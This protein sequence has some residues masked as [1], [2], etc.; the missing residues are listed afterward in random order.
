MPAASTRPCLELVATVTGRRSA[1]PLDRLSCPRA[2][3]EWLAAIGLPIRQATSPTELDDLRA[4]REA[5]YH[6]LAIRAGLA[7]AHH[8]EAHVRRLNRWA[9]EELPAP[10]LRLIENGRLSTTAATPAA[11]ARLALLARDAID[12]L[13]GPDAELLHQC[14]QADCGTFFLD[15]SPSRRRRW[16][17]STSCGNRARVSAYRAREKT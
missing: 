6:L 3:A 14:E 16:C 17:S 12:L 5:I 9:R 7:P 2:T 8:A 15:T 4:L 13:T 10:Q 11:R 1:A